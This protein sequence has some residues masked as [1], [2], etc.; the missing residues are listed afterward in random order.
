MNRTSYLLV[1]KTASRMACEIDERIENEW[2]TGDEYDRL[3][4]KHER[5]SRFIE[6]LRLKREFEPSDYTPRSD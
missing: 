6:Y 1:S 4:W 3:Q 2:H 5:L